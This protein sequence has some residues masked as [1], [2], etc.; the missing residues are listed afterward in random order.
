MVDFLRLKITDSLMYSAAKIL[1]QVEPI[2]R[3]ALPLP[4]PPPSQFMTNAPPV[5]ALIGKSKH[6]YQR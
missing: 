4:P 1:A 3:Q 6:I 5:S 2:E